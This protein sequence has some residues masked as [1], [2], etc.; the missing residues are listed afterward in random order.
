MAENENDPPEAAPHDSAADQE[1]HEHDHFAH[2][3]EAPAQ[4][5]EHS[6]AAESAPT[7]RKS[8]GFG[9][10]FTLLVAALGLFAIIGGGAAI[11]FKDKDE[12]LRAIAD[13]IEAAGRDPKGFFAEQEAMLGAWLT[14]T[15]PQ[16][17][18]GEAKAPPLVAE[19]AAPPA[20]P[21]ERASA[22]APT[23]PS[24]APGWANPADVRPASPAAR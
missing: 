3:H 20:A 9:Q 5:A 24:P 22:E 14:K 6:E 19:K 15:L 16:D 4:E 13:A 7:P 23:P 10:K 2:E 1:A 12:R 17:G 8:R 11:V 21:E 18:A